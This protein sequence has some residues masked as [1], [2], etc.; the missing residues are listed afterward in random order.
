[1]TIDFDKYIDLLK[2]KDNEA[3]AFVY[4]NTKRGVFSVIA[5]IVRDR[6]EVEDLM[7]DTYI[8]MLQNINSYQKGRNFTAWLFQIAKNLAIDHYRKQKNTTVLDPQEHEYVF[9]TE[10]MQKEG[11]ELELNE[12]I[13]IL[14]PEEKEIVLL[15][16]VSGNVFR[17]IA[18]IVDKPLGTVLWI[19]NKAIKKIRDHLG[20]EAES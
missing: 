6:S 13:G 7:Q 16:I 8:K 5:P 18:D 17:E 10:Q 15:K 3:F 4:E 1:V 12:V 2:E 20:K 11:S 9:D 14:T 19:Y